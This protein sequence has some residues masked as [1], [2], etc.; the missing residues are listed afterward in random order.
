MMMEDDNIV[1]VS[2]VNKADEAYERAVDV[3]EQSKLTLQQ[4]E[5]DSL[6][7]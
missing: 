2:E 3:Y 5:L 6:Q 7:R 1:T 4:V